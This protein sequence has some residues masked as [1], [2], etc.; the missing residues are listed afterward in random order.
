MDG[1]DFSIGPVLQSLT[2]SCLVNHFRRAMHRAKLD[3]RLQLL[4][5]RC[6][7]FG[8]WQARALEESAI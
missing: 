3:D 7:L 6:A 1:V 4:C 8:R 2:R 5:A